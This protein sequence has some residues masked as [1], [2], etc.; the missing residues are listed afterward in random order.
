MPDIAGSLPL[1]NFN[2]WFCSLVPREGQSVETFLPHILTPSKDCLVGCNTRSSASSNSSSWNPTVADSQYLQFFMDTIASKLTIKENEEHKNALGKVST[3]PRGD[4]RSSDFT[5]NSSRFP[6]NGSVPTMFQEKCLS[7][8]LQDVQV[9]SKCNN[10]IASSEK[11]PSAHELCK[12]QENSEAE[13]TPTCRYFPYLVNDFC[14]QQHHAVDGVKQQAS[15]NT[16]GHTSTSFAPA[17]STTASLP[18]FSPQSPQQNR[19]SDQPTQSCSSMKWEVSRNNLDLPVTY[20]IQPP[21]PG[22]I[23]N[24]PDPQSC[25]FNREADGTIP[26]KIATVPTSEE[27]EW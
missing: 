17:P 18:C 14:C 8:L 12:E 2:S 19:F 6:F 21:T 5:R 27:Q 25:Q 13:F 16:F 23:I 11:L 9:N 7:P 10:P 26:E 4:G 20:N 3:C 24:I 15:M 22:I 1:S